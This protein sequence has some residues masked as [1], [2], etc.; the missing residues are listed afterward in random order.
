MPIQYDGYSLKLLYLDTNAISNLISDYNFRRNVFKVVEKRDYHICFSIYNAI[1]LSNGYESRFKKFLEMFSNIPC[2]MFWTYRDIIK[3]EI[4]CYKGNKLD[5]SKISYSFVPNIE[6]E[7]DIRYCLERWIPEIKDIIEPQ[8]KNMEELEKFFT[9]QKNIG[10]KYVSF[11]KEYEKETTIEFLKE[12]GY[13]MNENIDIEKLPTCR[14]INKSIYN[15]ITCGKKIE[16]GTN[17]IY[18]IMISSVLSY[19]DAIVSENYQLEVIRQ[20]KKSIKQ[21]ENIKCYTITDFMK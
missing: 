7:Y 15:R 17:D 13:S 1:E 20:G 3:E 18:D 12:L 10:K 14:V 6:K 4:E 21:I 16:I 8:K 19:I 5:I 11:N 2:I 9:K